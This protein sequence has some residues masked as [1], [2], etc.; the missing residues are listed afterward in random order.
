MQILA[1]R[2]APPGAGNV[3]ARLDVELDDGVRLYQL[4]LVQGANGWRVYGPQ[5][6]G[7]TVVTLPLSIADQIVKEAVARYERQ[8]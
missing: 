8:S 6:N 5:Q 4:K 3:R 2:P 1:I 7:S